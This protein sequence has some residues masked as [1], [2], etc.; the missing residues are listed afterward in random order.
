MSVIAATKKTAHVKPNERR[1]GPFVPR[2]TISTCAGGW[3][4]RTSIAMF[5]TLNCLSPEI[6]SVLVEPNAVTGLRP[7]H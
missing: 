3:V 7:D 2:K 5:D 4:Q 1:V 6:P